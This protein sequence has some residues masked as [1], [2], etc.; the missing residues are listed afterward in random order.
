MSDSLVS[1]LALSRARCDPVAPTRRQQLLNFLVFQAAWFAAV[2]GA[3]HDRPLWGTGCVLAA[4]AWHLGVVAQPWREARL[5]LLAALI[6]ATVESLVVAQGNV[7]YASGQPVAWLAPHWMIALW[8]ELAIAL[9]VTMRWLKRRPLL[10]CALGAIAGPSSF[11]AGVRLGGAHFVAE[12]P[13]LLTLALMWAVMMPLLMWLSD[14]FD[15]VLPAAAE[16]QGA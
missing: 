1:P 16:T 14:R 15:G 12:R 4:I 8:G 10:A 7:V 11:A 6:G 2:L 3:A 13:A 5:V 9:N